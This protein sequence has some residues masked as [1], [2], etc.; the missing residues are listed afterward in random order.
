M[1]R[2]IF[3]IY[4]VIFLLVIT[5]NVYKLNIKQESIV[6]MIKYKDPNSSTI[7]CVETNDTKN[8]TFLYKIYNES[9]E[10]WIN[11]DSNS[12]KNLYLENG[13]YQILDISNY[14]YKLE[15]SENTIE[16]SDDNKVVTYKY[17]P[18]KDNYLKMK[19]NKKNLFDG[20][21]IIETTTFLPGIKIKISNLSTNFRVGDIINYEITISNDEDFEINDVI[22]EDALDGIML[23]E[24]DNYEILSEKIV[25]IPEIS[26]HGNVKIFAD[27]QVKQNDPRVINNVVRILSAKSPNR[28]MRQQVLMDEVAAF[29]DL[30]FKLCE[31]VTNNNNEDIFVFKI[32]N[33]NNEII[34]VELKNTECKSFGLEDEIYTITQYDKVGYKINSIEGISTNNDSIEIDNL[35][36]K[37]V[38]FINE[39]V[40]SGYHYSYG[41][42]KNKLNG[43]GT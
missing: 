33:S 25:K 24:N 20:T 9:F 5:F 36:E 30:N 34:W 28:K 1:K 43:G 15:S 16:I 31:Q 7:L 37:M 22:V 10:T 13:I 39:P 3:I 14:S 40:A 12:C 38:K 27:Y 26:A 18:I 42:G 6:N 4:L 17:K 19:G 21:E 29:V 2:K 11:V 32:E 35:S 8:N 23:I 41:Y